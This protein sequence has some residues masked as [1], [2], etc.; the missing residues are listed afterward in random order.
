MPEKPPVVL[1]T[2]VRWDALWEYSHVLATLFADAGY[3][4][5]FVET[6]GMRN[7][8][9]G[10]TTGRRVLKRLLR[11]RHSGGKKLASLSPNLTVYSP[12][13]VPPTHK[14][15]RRINHRIFVPRI[16]RDLRRLIGTA[17][18][19]MAFVPTRTTLNLVSGLEPRVI[20]YH[21]TLN[22]G[23]IPDAPVDIEETER[24][25]LMAADTVT[26]DSG[27]L[28]EKHCRVRP[29]TIRIESGVDFELFR[30]ADSGPLESP[31]RILYYFGRAY[32]RV[33]DFDLVREVV[34]AGF[35][36][37]I[38]GTL[39]EP[40]FARLPGVEYLGRVPHKV[41][42]E[43]LREADALI[44]P[45]KITPFTKGTFPAKTYEALATGKPVVTT[46]LP[47]LKRLGGHIY[48]GD[49]PEEFLRIL[50]RLHESETPERRRTRIDLARRNS[51]EARFAK[52]EEILWARL[53]EIGPAGN[54]TASR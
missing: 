19:V 34:E 23:E 49:G 54:P 52:F 51:W 1:L 9:L 28:K 12:L 15:F 7:P 5:V 35:T 37:R 43:H 10:I 6:T 3:P 20:W 32:E 26:A 17:P 47:D 2:N 18:V 42:P 40:S 36:L 14:A 53:G 4:T 41:L 27:F 44:I 21:C 48:L 29:D 24:Q 50:R 33:F 30:R 8:P 16:V 39:S 46:P 13:V 31:A 45:Y 22:Y 38:L 25:L 11:A